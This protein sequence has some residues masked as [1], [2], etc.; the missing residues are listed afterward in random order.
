[1]FPSYTLGYE[2]TNDSSMIIQISGSGKSVVS[3]IR[4]IISSASG[5]V[6]GQ[7]GCGCAE[8]GHISPTRTAGYY[9]HTGVVTDTSSTFGR[10]KMI[11][12]K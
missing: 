10:F 12:R 7:L 9:G 5:Y 11:R 3:G 1:M 2:P 4:R 8:Y 6:T